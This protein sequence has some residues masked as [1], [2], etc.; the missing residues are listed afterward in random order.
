PSARACSCTSLR[1]FSSC[2]MN[3]G[4]SVSIS[5]SADRVSLAAFSSARRSLT[6]CS[7]PGKPFRAKGCTT[8][9]SAVSCTA[10]SRTRRRKASRRSSPSAASTSSKR[11]RMSPCWRISSATTSSSTAWSSPACGVLSSDM[12]EL[13]SLLA[14]RGVGVL[15][16]GLDAVLAAEHVVVLG[17]HPV[18]RRCLAAVDLLLHRLEPLVRLADVAGPERGQVHLRVEQ[19]AQ[20]ALVRLEGEH[21]GPLGRE[22]RRRGAAVVAAHEVTGLVQVLQLHVQMQLPDR[23]DLGVALLL[24]EGVVEVALVVLVV[25][26]LL[27]PRLTRVDQRLVV[28]DVL[29]LDQPDLLV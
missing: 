7:P 1:S 8:S 4:S 13:P 10:S 24:H 22:H 17:H 20:V 2:G 26:Q 15:A 19:F 14:Q 25:D 29:L 18:A 12:R 3:F 27:P 16:L 6:T 5:S 21:V 28:G 11:L 23:L 9:S